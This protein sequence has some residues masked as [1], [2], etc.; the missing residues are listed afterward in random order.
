[1]S[2]MLLSKGYQ[3]GFEKYLG[4]PPQTRRAG[5]MTPCAMHVPSTL[6]KHLLTAALCDDQAWWHVQN[7]G[8][9]AYDNRNWMDLVWGHAQ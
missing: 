6:S 7:A 4:P 5:G 3:F 9:A 1:M 2:Q 8:F